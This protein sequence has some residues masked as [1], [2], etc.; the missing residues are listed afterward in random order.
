MHTQELTMTTALP[1]YIWAIVAALALTLSLATPAAAA[2]RTVTGIG[3]SIYES[4]EL[5]SLNIQLEDGTVYAT[6]QDPDMPA[7]GTWTSKVSS[8]GIVTFTCR[9]E[10]GG[11]SPAKAIKASST[12]FEFACYN[13]EEDMVFYTPKWDIHITPSGHVTY[14]CHYKPN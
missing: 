6:Q 11:T 13:A 10:V 8:S 2:S 7:G 4:P 14:S 1:R 12:E 9:G 5:C 3:L